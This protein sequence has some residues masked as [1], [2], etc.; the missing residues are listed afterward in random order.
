MS[1]APDSTIV[2]QNGSGSGNS[3]SEPE[4]DWKIL[5]IDDEPDIR[6]V[7]H[8]S[9]MDAGY[10][11]L[12][13]PDGVQG[14]ELLAD[15]SPQVVITDIKMPG[16]DGLEV[17]RQAKERF[18]ETEVIVT[19][20]FA[21]IQKATAALQNDASDFITKPVDDQR[22]HLALERAFRRYMDRKALADYT[23]LLEAENLKT[24]ADLIQKVDFQRRLIENS[25]D[26]ILGCDGDDR[27]VLYNK[28]MEDLLGYPRHE[29]IKVWGLGDFFE[30]KDFLALKQNLVRQ[31]YGG[32]DRLFLYETFM[33]GKAKQRMPV[34]VSGSL[35]IQEDAS[36]G[37]VLFIRD[38]A[39][40]RALEQTIRGQEKILHQEKMMSLGRLAA[41]IVHEINNPLSGILNYI[42]LMIRLSGQGPISPDMGDRFRDYLD[43]VDRETF[44]CSQLVSGLLKFSRKSKLE[45]APVDIGELVRYSIMLCNHKL[46]LSNIRVET[47]SGEGV[48]Q[49]LGDFNQLQQCL[50][51][52]IFNSLDAMAGTGG[53]AGSL[54]VDVRY[55]SGDK[56]VAIQVRDNGRGIAKEDLPYIFEPFFTT[57]EAGY[58]VGLGLSTAFGIVDHHKGNIT[59]ESRLG[60]GS[61][62][63]INLPPVLPGQNAAGSYQER[64]HD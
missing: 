47:S 20:G 13:A 57:K 46:E 15:H 50:I 61:C 31:G 8:L 54:R 7:I 9:L 6:E 19:T 30:H 3:P 52:L 37:L 41:S 59:V 60:K 42:R 35:V 36:R 48:P 21:D 58:G 44:R 18:P 17:L 38:L 43:I 1:N 51:N 14:L 29:V 4:P 40:I 27:V 63:T 28:A 5:L 45:F 32:P 12:C 49:V 64:G 23:C 22:L 11:V 34:Q 55:K 24:S 25:M 16:I 62:F 10:E 53:P 39:R 56:W 26:G 33:K 2:H